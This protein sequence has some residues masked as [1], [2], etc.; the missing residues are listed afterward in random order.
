MISSL[1]SFCSRVDDQFP[2]KATKEFL[3]AQPPPPLTITFLLNGITCGRC[4]VLF[5]STE[6]HVLEFMSMDFQL[7]F[8]PMML[9]A[10]QLLFGRRLINLHIM[11]SSEAI[12]STFHSLQLLKTTEC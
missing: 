11:T 3:S 8:D 5:Y 2:G 10:L 4:G 1:E 9:C 7:K 6:E 12:F